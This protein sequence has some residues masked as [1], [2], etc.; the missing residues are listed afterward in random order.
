MNEAL[1]VIRFYKTGGSDLLKI[2][3]I[4]PWRPTANEVFATVQAPRYIE[5]ND[6]IGKIAIALS[7]QPARVTKNPPSE[8]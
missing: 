3:E 1:K 5:T 8:A 6:Q 2:D 4:Q 7:S